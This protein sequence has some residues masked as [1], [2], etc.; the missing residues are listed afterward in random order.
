[1]II[2][3]P[4]I[5]MWHKGRKQFMHGWWYLLAGILVSLLLIFAFVFWN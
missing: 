4:A 5:I 2:S 3:G 1:M